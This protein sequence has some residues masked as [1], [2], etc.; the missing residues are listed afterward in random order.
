MLAFSNNI[1]YPTKISYVVYKTFK[2]F[3]IVIN[4][5]SMKIHQLFNVF[6]FID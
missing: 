2:S 3:N 4:L 1:I 5:T 6:N